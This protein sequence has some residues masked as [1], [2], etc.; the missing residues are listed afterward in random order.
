MSSST[1][2]HAYLDWVRGVAV[3]I[4]IE[5]HVL[6]AWTQAGDRSRPL[7]GYAMILGGFG[8]PLFLFLAGLAAVLS[9]E[10]KLRKTGDFT[11]SWR[12]VQ[13]RGWQI[14]GLA[15]LFR[16]QSYVLS[17]GYSLSSLLKVDILNIMGP[18]IATA[19]L[20]GRLARKWVVRF[21]LFAAAA[22]AVSL[23]TPLIREM[24]AVALLPDPI[25]WYFRPTPGRTN[26]TLF[27]WTGFVFAGAAVGVVLARPGRAD[28]RFQVMLAVIGLSVAWIA[29]EASLRPSP[30]QRSEYWTSSPSFFLLRAGLLVLLLP[31]GYA[32]VNAPWRNKLSNWRPLE[33]FGRSSLFV[34]WIHVEM[35]YGFFSRPLRRALTLESA[36]V[37]Y[38]LFTA[39]LLALVRLK[40]WLAEDRAIYLTDSKSV[41]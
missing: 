34:Y 14:F 35:V 41:I 9:A 2:R 40:S 33:E 3:L 37:A 15:F 5:A 17:G 21:V 38:V 23:V 4:M 22:T 25:E 36:L 8:A 26:F 10:S 12:A 24:P 29:H 16:L 30:Y 20:I 6:D 27:P 31:I 1:V 13:S 28:K 7:F 32:W 19:A 39:F 18:A 11:A